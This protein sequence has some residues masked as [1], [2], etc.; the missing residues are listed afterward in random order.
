M[1]K[2]LVVDDSPTQL[3]NLVKI[4][5]NH[6]HT[7]VTAT[8]GLEGYEVA[9]Q[10]KPDLILMD[11]VMP[12]LNGFQATRKITRD[13]ETQ[14][15]PVILVTTKDQ[16]TDKVWGERQGAAGYLI[17]P[18]QESELISKINELLG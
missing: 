9:K 18:P 14:H 5:Q 10:E 11:V 1:A 4:V 16:H 2:I 7:T 12:E 8:N 13:T 3:T 17:K 15:I 6:G